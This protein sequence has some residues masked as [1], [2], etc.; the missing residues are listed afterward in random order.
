MRHRF[1]NEGQRLFDFII[2][3]FAIVIR[4]GKRAIIYS[5]FLFS[6]YLL[7]KIFLR[8]DDHPVLLIGVICLSA[9]IIYSV[10]CL[11]I[12]KTCMLRKRKN[13]CWILLFLFCFLF[14]SVLPAVIIFKIS[15]PIV[16]SLTHDT[17]H[18]TL[19]T[20]VVAI[21]HGCYIF[22]LHHSMNGDSK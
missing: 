21:I 17:R 3:C 16:A 1:G 2:A 6:G 9:R 18:A 4:L 14:A 19:I 8:P 13:G 12:E 11:L 20:I 22:R 10:F 7:S 15:Y 5:P